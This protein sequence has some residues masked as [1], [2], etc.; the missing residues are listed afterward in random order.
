MFPT[1]ISYLRKLGGLSDTRQSSYGNLRLLRN[2][3]L[4][5]ILVTG[6]AAAFQLTTT[7]ERRAD[8]MTRHVRVDAW[9]VQQTEYELQR[10]RSVLARHVANDVEIPLIDVRNQLAH[11]GASLALM[12]RDNGYAEYG[13]LVDI[14]SAASMVTEALKKAGEVIG[15]RSELRGDLR[16]LN[17]IE[18]LLIGP[19]RALRQ[20]SVDIVSV[21]QELQDGD[22]SNVRWLIQANKWMLSIFFGATAV[23]VVLLALEIR[24]ARRAERVAAQSEENARHMADHDVLTE[25]PN[26]RRF[27]QHLGDCLEQAK[28]LR[29]DVALYLLDL[30]GFKDV[31]DTLG[32][33][34]GD[35][36]LVAVSARIGKMLTDDQLLVRLGGDEFAV[37]QMGSTTP[38]VW[39]AVSEGL[40][41]AFQPPFVIQ[42]REIQLGTSIGV[43][44]FPSDGQSVGDLLKA[45]D[46]ALYVA[47]EKRGCAVSFHADML[48]R[49]EEHAELLRDLK[50]AFED[51]A[52][53]V[54][55]QPQIGFADG[56]CIGAEALLRWRHPNHGWISPEK[57]IPIAEESG[58][59]NELG[60]WVL[61]AACRDA[62]RWQ[63]RAADAVVA[64][65]VSP[66][67]FRCSDMVSQVCRILGRTGLPANRLE[68]EITETVLMK[69]THAAIEAIHDLRDLGV[70]IAI[71]DFGTGFS[72][73]SYLRKFRIDKLK[74]DQSFVR[75]I[76]HDGTCQNIVGT[77][78]ELAHGIGAR[79]IAEGIETEPQLKQLTVLGC[80]EGQGFFYARPMPA[81][82]LKAFMADWE[83]AMPNP[84]TAAVTA[85]LGAAATENIVVFPR[86]GRAM[87]MLT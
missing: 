71:D 8:G 13:R 60:I 15:V 4:A 53:E 25:L 57:F 45:A 41:A 79:T 7:L 74:I 22:L 82:D 31:N 54:H 55:Y 86:R 19:S 5:I 62:S 1:S 70:K 50:Q 59:I 26:R 83:S 40:I 38:M 23:F 18:E 14:D 16:S 65:N 6:A 80:E 9:A 52:L 2:I 68:L 46:L 24:G 29:S 27:E 51:E 58:L 39:Q 64:V 81:S 85:S 20:L 10:F 61:E 17:G 44:R 35:E 28:V 66:S 12:R 78:I 34:F 73:L 21:R 49:A 48:A 42:D 63:G 84:E 36:L 33:A 67:Q 3:I 75:D 37:V 77:V 87:E 56:N 32:H 43:A 76:E 47:K 72:S 69:G 11:V 30:D